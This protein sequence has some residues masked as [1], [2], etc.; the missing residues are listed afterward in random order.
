MKVFA[1]S[2]LLLSNLTSVVALASHAPVDCRESALGAAV[3][4]EAMRSDATGFNQPIG[5][6][7]EVTI[8]SEQTWM[9]TV[10]GNGGRPV[11]Y[12]VK[13]SKETCQPLEE[14]TRGQ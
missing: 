9:A 6:V 4:A 14:P 7:L 10:T 1:L 2:I 3:Q 5:A 12:S 13:V 11:T 8:G